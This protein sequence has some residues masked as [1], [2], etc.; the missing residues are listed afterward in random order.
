MRR[1]RILTKLSV[2]MPVRINGHLYVQCKS[3]DIVLEYPYLTIEF[4][5]WAE[6][7]AGIGNYFDFQ[8]CYCLM[9]M[10]FYFSIV[11]IYLRNYIEYDSNLL[12]YH[13]TIEA[14]DP[15]R[16]VWETAGEMPSSRS[17]LSC[18]PL[19]VSIENVFQ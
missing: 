11:L 6:K 14:Y 19:V 18:V 9:I 17:W 10:E 8:S 1:Q 15:V 5:L 4:M 7:K 3:E 13:D 2:M 12:R 16:D